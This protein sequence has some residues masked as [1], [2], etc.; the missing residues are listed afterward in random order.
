ML[1]S[2]INIAALS[3]GLYAA[4]TQP[5]SWVK[6]DWQAAKTQA[7]KHN[8]LIAVDVWAT[9]CHTCLAMKNF[10]F[11]EPKFS[12]VES[13]HVWLALDYDRPKNADFFRKYSINAFPTFM[14]IDPATDRVVSR[15]LGSGTAEEM[16]QFFSLTKSDIS[17]ES[18]DVM[19]KIQR[20][21]SDKKYN[22]AIELL[23]RN[24]KS[25]KD[26]ARKTRLLSAYAEALRKTDPVGCATKNEEF[27]DQ[28]SNNAQGLDYVMLV[29]YCAGS[30][31]EAS[32]KTR[33]LTKIAQRLVGGLQSK[34]LDI[35]VDDHS[36]VLSALS[37]LYAQLGKA[38]L[39]HRTKV[40]QM[41]LLEKAASNAGS[42]KKRSTFDAHRFSCYL[43]LGEFAKAEHMLRETQ[44]ALPKDFNTPWRL[45]L[46]Y[47]KM[48]R[49]EDG[50]VAID[51]ALKL[52]Y[53][54]RRVRLFS[55]KIDL[56]VAKNDHKS[57]R[58]VASA[59]RAEIATQDKNLIRTFWLNELESKE[60]LI[61]SRA[62]D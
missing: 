39:A 15:W 16:R 20:A 11:T 44:N 52:G 60:K 13:K 43:S 2:L 53:G 57:A 12:D 40:Q 48:G 36:T 33:I 28:V 19:F 24:L 22:A 49:F 4:E 55:A 54:P 18:S 10:V 3:T 17:D 34:D 5:I 31:K 23:E 62:K 56:L 50:L 37:D 9:W 26:T 47:R 1:G 51:R 27:L 58:E 29:S 38:S 14:L 7:L 41:T 61:Q 35:S 59:V 46:L 32:D 45:A 25:E 21:L 6:D 8:K 42:Q 30:V